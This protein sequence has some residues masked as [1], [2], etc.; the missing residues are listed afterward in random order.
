M[1]NNKLTIVET[2]RKHRQPFSKT[3]NRCNFKQIYSRE[4]KTQFFHSKRVNRLFR[5]GLGSPRRVLLATIRR[6]YDWRGRDHIIDW[7]KLVLWHLTWIKTRLSSACSRSNQY[8]F[9]LNH[10]RCPFALFYSDSFCKTRLC[11]MS[12]LPLNE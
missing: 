2:L 10:K 8:H 6:K 11:F 3:E 9:W 1:L 4:Y 7:R 12:N 5:L